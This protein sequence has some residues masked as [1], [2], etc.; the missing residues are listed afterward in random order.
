MQVLGKYGDLKNVYVAFWKSQE[1]EEG[2]KP[3]KSTPN[4][5]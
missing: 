2:G 4:A 1:G 5:D 3:K